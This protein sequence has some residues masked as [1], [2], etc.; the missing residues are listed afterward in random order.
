MGSIPSLFASDTRKRDG[1]AEGK[2]DSNGGTFIAGACRLDRRN[3]MQQRQ[4]GTGGSRSAA[5]VVPTAFSF[6]D[7]VST[8]Q[9]TEEVASFEMPSSSERQP[10]QHQHHQNWSWQLD[11]DAARLAGLGNHHDTLPSPPVFQ[12]PPALRR[13][14]GGISGLRRTTSYQYAMDGDDLAHA[15]EA[16]SSGKQLLSASVAEAAASVA[17]SP[18]GATTTTTATPTKRH[19]DDMLDEGRGQRAPRWVSDSP[20]SHTCGSEESPAPAPEAAAAAIAAEAAARSQCSPRRRRLRHSGAAFFLSEWTTASPQRMAE[21]PGLSPCPC[22]SSSP[23]SPASTTPSSLSRRVQRRSKLRAPQKDAKD[24]S[25]GMYEA[26]GCGTRGL[27]FSPTQYWP[28]PSLPRVT[29]GATST[30]AAAAAAA[31]AA[32]VAAGG[33][34]DLAEMQFELDDIITPTEGAAA[35]TTIPTTT[36][37]AAA[38]ATAPCVAAATSSV[39]AT[40]TATATASSSSMPMMHGMA[41]DDDLAYHD[42]TGRGFGLVRDRAASCGVAPHVLMGAAGGLAAAVQLDDHLLL[43]TPAVLGR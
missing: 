41:G 4:D 19:R 8:N 3:S 39:S 25:V 36:A 42:G 38:V 17:P 20:F 10:Y 31:A 14:G 18:A 13:K 34:A 37:A 15:V 29:A 6:L 32:T 23:P 43:A 40:A 24:P 35:G 2:D 22:V 5:A 30:A 1:M 27:R 28:S 9:H 21:D 12:H 33:G 16:T 26:R 11:D 7:D